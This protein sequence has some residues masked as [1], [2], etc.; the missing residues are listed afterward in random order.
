MYFSIIEKCYIINSMTNYDENPLRRA[1][2]LSQAYVRS[3]IKQTLV[4]AEI[5]VGIEID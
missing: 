3:M 2:A 4:S 5:L 1:D